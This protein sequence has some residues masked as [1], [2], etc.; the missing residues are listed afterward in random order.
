MYLFQ[1]STPVCSSAI[2]QRLATVWFIHSFSSFMPTTVAVYCKVSGERFLNVVVSFWIL[3]RY[4][5]KM[6]DSDPHPQITLA[7]PWPQCFYLTAISSQQLDEVSASLN[8]CTGSICPFQRC[9]HHHA[10]SSRKTVRT[11]HAGDNTEQINTSVKIHFA[12]Y[13]AKL[14]IK[15]YSFINVLLLITLTFL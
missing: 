8:I 3:L 13:C 15:S 4:F 2:K 11:L 10:F 6:Y 1:L 9:V 5:Q 7:W 14:C 12:F